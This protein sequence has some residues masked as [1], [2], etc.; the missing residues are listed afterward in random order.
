MLYTENIMKKEILV[1]MIA[2][3]IIDPALMNEIRFITF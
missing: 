1:L 3:S 2:D